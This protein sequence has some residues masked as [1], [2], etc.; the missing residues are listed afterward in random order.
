MKELYMAAHEELI[1]EYLEAHP[2]ATE[3][4]AYHKTADAA[5]DR[6]VDKYAGMIDAA[7]DRAKYE[8]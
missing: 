8:R 5:Y 3:A 4:E 7:R 1:G 6:Y 2:D